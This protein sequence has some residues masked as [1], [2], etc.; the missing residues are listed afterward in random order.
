[1]G[2]LGTLGSFLEKLYITS[3]QNAIKMQYIGGVYE[4]E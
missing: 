1:M 2:G 3:V 4:N